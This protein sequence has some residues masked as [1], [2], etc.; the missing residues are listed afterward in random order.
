MKYLSAFS[1]LLALAALTLAPLHGAR[2][3]DIDQHPELAAIVDR[4]VA[5]HG[6]DRGTVEGWIS[7][8]EYKDSIIKA[9]T[10]PAEALPWHRYRAL[11]ITDGSIDNGVKFVN[12]HRETLRRA[13]ETY[14]VDPYIIAAIIG[15]ETRYGTVTGNHRIIDA[16]ATL[17][18]GYP[19]RSEFF[20]KELGEYLVLASA[21]GIDPLAAKG[22]YAGAIGIPQFMPSSYRHYSVDFDGDGFDNLVDNFEDAIGSVAN[23]LARHKWRSGEPVVALLGRGSEDKLLDELRTT[24]LKPKVGISKLDVRGLDIKPGQEG[25]MVGVVRMELEDGFDYRVGYHNFFVITTY[26]RS[27][28]YAMVAYDLA[29][30]IAERMN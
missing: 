24:G 11:F 13:S 26:N 23:Y 8:A 18:V 25:W 14:G 19:R 16:L 4:V 2:A 6:L 10:R 5:E 20:G 21:N 7:A 29:Y 3:L 17:T 9:I 28:N 15:I 27:Q 22:S 12:A 1:R 30:A